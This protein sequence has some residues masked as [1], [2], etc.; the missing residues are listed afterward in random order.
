[1]AV[2][3]FL[4]FDPSAGIKG[5]SLDSQHGKGKGD[6]I[7]IEGFGFSAEA[8][9]SADTGTGLGSGKL[10]FNEFAFKMKS[11]TASYAIYKNLCLGTHIPKATL[12]LRKAGGGSTSGQKDFMI[13]TFSQLVITKWG[14]DGGSE[15]PAEDVSFAYTSLGIEYRQ[16]KQDGSVSRAGNGWKHWDIKNQCGLE[17]LTLG[18]LFRGQTPGT[19]VSIATTRGHRRCRVRLR[20]LVGSPGFESGIPRKRRC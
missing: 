11:S 4:E 12:Y 17:I 10:K 6:S 14:L 5:E 9:A 15:E 3:A 1:M 18:M 8:P 19:E 2:D 20:W 13:Y 7:Q 16:Q